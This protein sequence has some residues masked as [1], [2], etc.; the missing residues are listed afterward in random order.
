MS[1]RREISVTTLPPPQLSQPLCLAQLHHSLFCFFSFFPLS[2][3]LYFLL[4]FFFNLPQDISP[5]RPPLPKSYLPLESPP[6][7][8][9]STSH[10][11]L[12][13]SSWL[14]RMEEDYE[15]EEEA[16]RRQVPPQRKGITASSSPSFL[17]SLHCHPSIPKPN[18]KMP[19]S[20]PPTQPSP[21]PSV[22]ISF[23]AHPKPH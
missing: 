11:S 21:P 2:Y 19:A 14:C 3:S 23:E 4:S 8:P 6:P 22:R 15:E 10:L 18:P 5:P 13:R 20:N 9:L 7:F 12:D 16:R 17:R 1:L